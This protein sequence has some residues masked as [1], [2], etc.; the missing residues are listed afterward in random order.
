MRGPRGDVTLPGKEG[1]VMNRSGWMNRISLALVFGCLAA[2]VTFASAQTAVNFPIGTPQ[3]HV[4]ND[5]IGNSRFF[6]NPNAEIVRV[7]VLATPSP[8]T[9][10]F[11]TSGLLSLNGAQTSVFVG[12]PT[13]TNPFQMTFIGLSSGLGGSLNNYNLNFDKANPLVQGVLDAWD[14]TPFTITVNNASAPG[15]VSLQ[16]EAAD[17]DRTMLP[18]MVTD[19]RVI[20]DGL[21]PR[22]EWNVPPTGT[23]PTSV[24]IQIRRIE[25]ESADRSRITRAT[26]VHQR[27]LAPGATGYTVNEVFSNAA[28]P[29]FPSGLEAGRRYEIA[30]V[31]QVASAGIIKGRART[32]FEF[33]PLAGGG[34]EVAVYLPS[35]GPNGVFKFDITV[36]DGVPVI[37][38]PAIAVGYI[39]ET[40]AG[41][42]NFRSV[43][44]PDVGDGR[45]TIELFDP[46]LN[47]YRA[48]FAAAAGWT[49]DFTAL[50]HPDG[51]AK[52]RVKGI[53]ASAGLDA[54]DVTAFQTTV[55][56]VGSGRFTGTMTPIVAYGTAGGFLSPVNAAPTPTST[57]AGATLPLKWQL[58]DREGSPIGD[59]GAVSEITYKATSCTF[60]ADAGGVA[61]QA[62]GDSMLRYDGLAGHYVFNWKTP[63]VAG[64]YVVFVKL[65]TEQV[66]SAN[67]ILTK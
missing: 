12:H 58:T 26:L 28:L 49:Y 7:A 2:C 23:P 47:A 67:V 14:A 63:G 52:F 61:A 25:A 30:V 41:D 38:D 62:A 33:S 43:K 44:L 31:L 13:F 51:V 8:D 20:G 35:V 32:F 53:E 3:T 22:L 59:L 11:E 57:R 34:S 54:G 50:G 64:C 37:I 66:M 46:G 56:F 55:S 21:T 48:P 6:A 24:L 16:F 36:A 42:P 65:D 40:G 9:D 10:V 19:L 4:F 60:G 5:R 15:P 45:Y 27:N 29:G 18:A 17:Y 39:Y 1:D